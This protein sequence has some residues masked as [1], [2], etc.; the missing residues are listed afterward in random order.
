MTIIQWIIV[1]LAA[2]WIIWTTSK[3]IRY[4]QKVGE[5][6]N[7]Y[8][9]AQT[10]KELTQ[11]VVHSLEMQLLEEKEKNKNLISQKTS[12]N[13]RMGAI[14]ENL[15][16][17]LT[18]LPYNPKN[19][20]HLANPIDFIY[21]NYDGSDGPEVVFVEV[22]SGAARESSRQKLIQKVIKEGRVHYDLVQ[23][24]EKGIKVT[25]KV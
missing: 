14:A 8:E 23:I 25:R 18:D 6:K 22:K 17:L 9:T 24:N 11:T 20:H 16:P 10:E 21:F 19:L 15:L 2:P 1:I 12:Q 7:K 3:A 5:W 13:V 4:S